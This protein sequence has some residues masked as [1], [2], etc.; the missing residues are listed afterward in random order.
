M[1]KIL[2]LLL[3][4][5]LCMGSASAFSLKNLL[6]NSSKST[7]T[8]SSSSS[9]STSDILSKLGSLVSNATASS[10]FELT[11]LVGTWKYVSPAVSFESDNALQK[12]G[13]AAASTAIEEKLA[14]YY[15]TAGL[16]N[17]QLTVASDLTFT[18]KLKFGTLT[19][20]I[21]KDSNNKLVFNFSAYGTISIGKISAQA[22]KSG[23]TLNLTFDASKVVSIAKKVSAVTNNS[24]LTTAT[25]LLSS[26]DGIYAG[27]KL[28]SK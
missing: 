13:G 2:S 16:T 19:G 28:S 12:I 27:F 10:S 8:T 17:L 14:P 26:Y 24:T 6:K 25:D 15:K 9:N 1:K 18:M 20:T 11:D 3:V 21:E 22:T 23:S 4:I 7:T 5:A